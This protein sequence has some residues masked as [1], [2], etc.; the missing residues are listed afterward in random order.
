VSVNLSP[1]FFTAKEHSTRAYNNTT[2]S[3]SGNIFGW[4]DSNV[5]HA[6]KEENTVSL[7]KQARKEIFFPGFLLRTCVD[8]DQTYV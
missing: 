1:N 7:T 8:T 4:K 5:K 6:K 2:L 3:D